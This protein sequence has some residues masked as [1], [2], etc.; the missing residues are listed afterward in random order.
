MNKITI[1][2]LVNFFLW[3][4]ML[5]WGQSD[6][7]IIEEEE[8][9]TVDYT[10]MVATQKNKAYCSARIL[11]QTPQKLISVGY[12]F[13]TANTLSA[14][15]FGDFA[16]ETE[17]IRLNRG[18]RI[19]V[20]YPIISKNSI[21]VNLGFNY[22]ETVY[23]FAGQSSELNH[24]LLKSLNNNGLRSMGLNATVFKPLNSKHF[25]L[26]QATANLNGDYTFANF[27]SLRYTRY[28]G[29]VVFGWKAHDRRM[30]GLGLSRSYLAGALNYF[31][32][33]YYMYSSE[34]GKWGIEALAPARV[35]Y[36]RNLS[37]KDLLLIGYDLQGNS[38]RLNNRNNVFNTTTFNELELRR[39]ELRLGIT[40]ER[41]LSRLIWL[42]AQVGYRYNWEYNIDNGDFFRSLFDNKPFLI[43]N[44]LSNPLYVGISLNWVSL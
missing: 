34:N 39:A 9:E 30:W 32:V 8:T 7:T 41:A 29:A 3:L 20:N 18:L 33:L 37:K 17:N 43:D 26:F 24:P 28:G 6:S 25:L 27:Q 40:Y 12:D 5:G 2:S 35:Q 16:E 36:R 1:F 23:Q 11:S 13:Q 38:F 4:P 10:Q 44:K 21:L 14:G 42:S 15:G 31:P 19:G 22:A